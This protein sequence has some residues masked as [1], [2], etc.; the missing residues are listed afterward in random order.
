M[1]TFLVFVPC[2][3]EQDAILPMSNEFGRLRLELA[4]KN[5]TLQIVWVDD[6]SSD[7]TLSEIKIQCQSLGEW[8][9][10]IAHDSN[11]GLVGVLETMLSQW[12]NMISAS[13]MDILGVGL[14]DGDNSHPSIYFLD[15]IEKLQRGYDVVVA[16]RFQVGSVIEGVPWNRQILSFA[17]SILFRLA[18]RVHNIRDYSCGFRAYSPQILEKVGADFKFQ[19]RSFACMV[20]L[21][22][23]CH[24][25]N[26]FFCEV[27]FIL[28]YDQKLSG[29]KMKVVRTVKETLGVLLGQ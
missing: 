12:K 29:S 6:K 15:M 23:A 20:E 8:Q 9:R 18:G 26:A 17:M 25:K 16:S 14:L 27:P 22:M 13:G 28:R 3:N 2:Y 10:Y 4:R 21:L 7:N 19:K 24:K 1:S 5:V 11:R